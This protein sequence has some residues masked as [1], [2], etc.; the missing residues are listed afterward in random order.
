MTTKTESR[1]VTTQEVANA[2]GVTRQTVGN[3]RRAGLITAFRLTT[4]T[5]RYD[6]DLIRAEMRSAKARK[7]KS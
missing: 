6:L 3:W 5:V 1:L 4:K 7:P 2:L